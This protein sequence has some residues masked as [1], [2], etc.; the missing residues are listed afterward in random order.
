MRVYVQATNNKLLLSSTDNR[1]AKLLD[2]G[3]IDPDDA[4]FIRT[5]HEG[6]LIINVDY[7]ENGNLIVTP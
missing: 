7:D 2:E 1:T 5:M 4:F 6:A 3:K